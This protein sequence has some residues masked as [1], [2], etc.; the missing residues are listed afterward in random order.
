M[1]VK[2]GVADLDDLAL[3]ARITGLKAIWYPAQADPECTRAM[4]DSWGQQTTAMVRKFARTARERIRLGGG[5]NRR[6]HLRALAQRVE[7][8][9]DEVR[10]MG[11][12]GDPLRILAAALGVKSAAGGVHSSVL[13][14][15]RG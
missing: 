5:G 1:H 3:K 15:R 4:L 12:T 8:A 14:W 10:I 11:S 9:E 7:V 2:T 6:D 13:S